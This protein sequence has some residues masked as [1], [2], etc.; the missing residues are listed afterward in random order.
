MAA[1]K[2][3]STAAFGDKTRRDWVG[4]LSFLESIGARDLSH[5]E[6]AEKVAATGDASP[7]WAQSITVAFEQHIGRRKPGQRNSGAFEVSASRTVAEDRAGLFARVVAH[8]GAA[9]S[10]GG[11]PV[12][13]DARISETPKRSYWRATLVD[14]STVQLA[15]EPKG[16]GK[17]MLNV[18]HMKLTAEA[19]IARW[20]AFWK[21]ELGKF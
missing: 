6:I 18:T 21:D 15:A 20:R 11:V 7:W 14:G 13:P 4:W 8:F 12:G 16:D 10:L 1:T 17:T 19:D 3:I 5:A 9:R 2:P